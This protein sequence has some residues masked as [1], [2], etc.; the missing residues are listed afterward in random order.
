[1]KKRDSNIPQLRF[2]GFSADWEDKLLGELLEFKNGINADKEKYG[3]GVKFVN[4]LDILNNEFITYNK[5]VGSID[6][7][8]VKLQEYP[9]NYGDILF[10]RS[11][12][13]REEVGTACVYLD[14]ENTATFGGFIIRG[15]KVGNYDPIFLNKL[16]KTER[17]RIEITSK[18]G[19]STRYNV[20]QKTL[21]SVKLLF[22]TLPE[23][24]KIANFLSSVDEKIQALQKKKS[25]LEQY[26]KGVMQKIF[27]QEIH[28]KDEQGMDFP[29]WVE[30]RLGEV[31]ISIKSGRDKSYESGSFPVY[32]STGQIGRNNY[33]TFDGV[34]ILVARVGA[35]AGKL[36]IVD[37]KFGV[38]DNT[39]VITLPELLSAIYIY[40]FLQILN[41][42][43]FIFGSGQPLITGSQLKK[44]KI[45]LPIYKEQTKIANF[46][47]SIDQKIDLINQQ[48]EKAQ[49]WKKGLL[50][51]LF[52]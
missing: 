28:F 34:Y 51:K 15:K 22:P 2:P 16:L 5:I 30:R 32:G 23:Q 1:M 39:L 8:A 36:N 49:K 11:S 29:E 33:Y 6:I 20:G 9:V 24:T 45:L 13:T 25:L 46:L 12:E 40:E 7:D 4:V 26:K 27:S 17:A 44:I 10:Q 38:T 42:N 52:V 37:G 35:N 41:L 48:I 31:V 21:A 18:S 43:R 47:S 3:K 50:Q 19:G 14:K